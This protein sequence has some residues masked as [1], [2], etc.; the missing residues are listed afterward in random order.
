MISFKR[1]NI[2]QSECECLVNTVNCVQ[3]MGKGLA[4]TFKNKFPDMFEAYKIACKT[5]ELAIGKVHLY[6]TRLEKPKFIVN[7]PTKNDWRRPSEL[8]YIESGLVSL[9]EVILQNN[10]VSIAIPPLG[11]GLGGLNWIQVRLL[12]ANFA[13]ELPIKIEIYEPR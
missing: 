10:I 12:L 6:K 13:E 1:G 11:C 7:F 9:K 5:G 8:F 2:F 4:L 3:V